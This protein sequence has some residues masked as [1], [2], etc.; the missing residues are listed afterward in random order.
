MQLPL[1][2][3]FIFNCFFPF[4]LFVNVSK[5]FI[6]IYILHSQAFKMIFYTFS[7][8]MYIYNFILL[9]SF[10]FSCTF[11]GSVFWCLENFYLR[12]LGLIFLFVWLKLFSS[13][14]P[15]GITIPCLLDLLMYDCLSF[16]HIFLFCCLFMLLPVYFT[17]IYISTYLF[18]SKSI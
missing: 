12:F 15:F 13:H 14:L 10:A 8:C 4:S 2:A 1:L 9:H 11:L 7:V 5:H 18:S 6:S 3:S 16:I 17:L